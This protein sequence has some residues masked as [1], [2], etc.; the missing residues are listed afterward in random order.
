MAA[1]RIK[2]LMAFGSSSPKK[3]SKAA[4]NIFVA[5]LTLDGLFGKNEAGFKWIVFRI[6]SFSRNARQ[7]RIVETLTLREVV[8]DICFGSA[9]IFKVGI[10]CRILREFFDCL[11][12]SIRRSGRDDPHFQLFD[13]FV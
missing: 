12:F 4:Y 10:R 13:E 1:T 2:L 5:K 11:Y 3:E 7:V 6:L 8:G 9:S